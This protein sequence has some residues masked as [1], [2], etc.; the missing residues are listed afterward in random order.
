MDAGQGLLLLQT[1][2]GWSAAENTESGLYLPEEMT[3]M[4]WLTLNLERY[5][6][7]SGIHQQ[8]R[9]YHIRKMSSNHESNL[10][11]PLCSSS[12]RQA[13]AK[14]QNNEVCPDQASLVNEN[15]ELHYGGHRPR[16][17]HTSCS[18]PHLCL[19]GHCGLFSISLHPGR[20]AIYRETE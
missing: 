8:V 3:D 5:L 7:V 6:L 16:C 17:V 18:Q 13:S 1:P 20:N 4:K 10:V 11:C 15:H 2:G 19:Y 12:F 9:S 14:A